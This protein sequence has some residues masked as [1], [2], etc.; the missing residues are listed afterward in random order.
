MGGDDPTVFVCLWGLERLVWL[1]FD[2]SNIREVAQSVR[3]TYEGG[4]RSGQSQ[5]KPD[6]SRRHEVGGEPSITHIP[7]KISQ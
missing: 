7:N 3:K 6:V 1:G 4:V 2:S 5:W